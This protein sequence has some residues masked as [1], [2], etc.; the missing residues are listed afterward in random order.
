MGQLIKL[1]D[2]ISRY[3]QDI[4][5]YPSRYVRLKKQQWG[6]LQTSWETNSDIGFESLF[7]QQ[8]E[9]HE[10]IEDE[11]HPIMNKLKGL[12]KRE[13]KDKENEAPLEVVTEMNHEIDDPLEDLSNEFQSSFS[14]KPASLDDLKQQFL[15]QLFQFQMKWASSTLTGKSFVDKHFYFEEKLKYFLQRFPDNY[16]VMYNP[17]FLV[18][19]APIEAEIILISPTDVWCISFLEE[20]NQSVFIGSKE[21]F[22]T[23][24]G[25][26]EEK[27]V[28]NPTIALNRTE[29]IV[30]NILRK[31]EIDLP[32]HKIVLSRNGFIDYPMAPLD[33]QLIEKRNYE[34]WFTKMR[35]HRSPIKH[36][37]LKAAQMLLE[38]C[39]TNA[40]RR[41]EWDHPD[42]HSFIHHD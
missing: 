15:D 10:W 21:R 36:I 7:Q 9:N 28:L 39:Q 27:K 13:H 35:A 33:I 8:P 23:K 20:E 12:L 42:H 41:L 34:E 22:W 18:K 31:Y 30:H 19:K 17:M 1:Q 4:F 16:L 26:E 32:I 5:L 2:Y 29:K 6:K 14:Y 37:Q 38:Y 24:R 3:E 25:K 40:I 11:K